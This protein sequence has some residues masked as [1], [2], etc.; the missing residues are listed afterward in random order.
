M[1]SPYFLY[2]NIGGN[3]KMLK[4]NL[5]F[6]KNDWV[7]MLTRKAKIEIERAQRKK[8]TD[9]ANDESAIEILSNLDRMD[10]IQK[11]LEKIEKSKASED[12]KAKKK[13]ELTKEILPL[14]L[15]MEATEVFENEIDPCEIIY[16]LIRNN[17]KNKPLTKEEFEAGMF[18]LED[19]LGLMDFEK[20][21]RGIV[22]QVFTDIEELNKLIQDFKEPQTK[23]EEKQPS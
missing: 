23:T 18:E 21:V 8:A 4:E 22:D 20:K 17:P 19:K 7:V 15:K 6:N 12:V 1:T 5:R 2:L 14:T 10:E 16:I 11:E 13:I 9:V 3:K